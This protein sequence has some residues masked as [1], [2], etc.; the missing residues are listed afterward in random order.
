MEEPE[1]LIEDVR[2]F[3][4]PLRAE[5][6][7]GLTVVPNTPGLLRS[8]QCHVSPE[9]YAEGMP[10]YDGMAELWWPD[11]ASA[12]RVAA[13]PEFRVEQLNDA[14]QFVDVGHGE[15]LVAEEHRGIWPS[16][17]TRATAGKV[18]R[19]TCKS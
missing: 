7:A 9:T 12:E 2:T 3:F 6:R 10:T 11:R 13:S 5:Q 17:F 19:Q 14:R 8:G 1:Q 4:R 16:R 18:E 15:G